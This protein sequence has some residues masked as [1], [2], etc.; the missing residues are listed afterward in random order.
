VSTGAD[1]KFYE[2]EPGRWFY[3]LQDWPYGDWPEYHTYGPFETFDRAKGHLN[4][5]HANPGGWS[6]EPL[7]GCP[8]DLAEPLDIARAHR[9]NWTH[10][11]LRC[12]DWFVGRKSD[13]G[14]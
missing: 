4:H 9:G 14:E 5:N 10:R 1:C 11:C 12:G 6:R 3:D 8:H 7:P 2:K 13:N